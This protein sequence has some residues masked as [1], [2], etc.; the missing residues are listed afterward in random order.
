MRRASHFPSWPILIWLRSKVYRAF[1]DFE[2]I[3]LHGTFL[4]DGA[5]RVRLQNIS[6]EP[7]R[8][9]SWL[10]TESQRL[11]AMPVEEKKTSAAAQPDLP[12]HL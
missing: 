9:A 10:L 3:P 11:L 4:I 1:D 2:H 6:Y 12:A 7:F 5:G 8:D